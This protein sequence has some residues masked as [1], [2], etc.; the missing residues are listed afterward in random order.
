MYIRVTFEIAFF[1]CFC[2]IIS[3][4]NLL[5]QKKLT[6]FFFFF[7]S[8]PSPPSTRSKTRVFGPFFCRAQ[9]L[10]YT[11][12]ISL[13]FDY[14]E[15]INNISIFLMLPGTT[16][17]TLGWTK[18]KKIFFYF[19]FYIRAKSIA[20]LENGYSN[21]L[22]ILSGFS[23]FLQNFEYFSKMKFIQRIIMFNIL[24]TSIIA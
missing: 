4:R 13:P 22:S 10:E 5:W 9:T 18:K 11:A 2:A 1:V 23:Q 6:A 16:I 20:I 17:K 24:Y 8:T 7:I 14:I 19:F 12:I 21:F 3:I 15:K